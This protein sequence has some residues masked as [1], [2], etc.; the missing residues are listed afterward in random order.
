MEKGG[1]RP[2]SENNERRINYSPGVVAGLCHCGGLVMT[3]RSGMTSGDAHMPADFV[4]QCR[5]DYSN[6]R[7]FEMMW[8][9]SN[10]VT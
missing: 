9:R 6:W 7:L 2:S 1:Y 5:R 3:L 8:R 10:G 4:P